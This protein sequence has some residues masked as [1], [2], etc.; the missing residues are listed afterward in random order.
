MSYPFEYGDETL[1]DAGYHSG[2]LYCALARGAAEFF[3][4]APGLTP[5]PQGSCAVDGEVFQVFV[6]RLYK[7]Y[8]STNNEV[9]RGLVH[10]LLVT[11]LVLLDRTGGR[12]AVRPQD[13]AALDE[14]KA[15]LARTMAS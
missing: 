3:D 15:A 12:I 2:Q 13:A 14:A 11:S 4:V 7:Q 5:T 9:L 1:W 6:Q 10:P 8:A